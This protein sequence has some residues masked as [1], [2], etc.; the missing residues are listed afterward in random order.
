MRRNKMTQPPEQHKPGC[1]INRRCLVVHLDGICPGPY[2]KCSCHELPEPEKP[3]TQPIT[4]CL[5][6]DCPERESV[7]CGAGSRRH[8]Q[9]GASDYFVC[10][11]CHKEFIGG[12]C[13]AAE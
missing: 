1:M 12:K 11:K 4:T 3:M 7:C 2:G 6:L 9:P 8:E 13:T 10:A 5:A